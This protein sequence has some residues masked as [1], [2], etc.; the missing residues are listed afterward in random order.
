VSRDGSAQVGKCQNGGALRGLEYGEEAMIWRL[1]WRCT[2][3]TMA[4]AI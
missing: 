3:L 1:L 2:L 4:V